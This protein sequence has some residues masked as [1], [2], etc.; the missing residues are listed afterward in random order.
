MDEKPDIQHIRNLDPHT[1]TMKRYDPRGRG[2]DICLRAHSLTQLFQAIAAAEKE[3]DTAGFTG[4]QEYEAAQAAA[5]TATQT[6]PVAPA[7]RP[8]SVTAEG[9]QRPFRASKM[10]AQWSD[11]RN[12]WNWRVF[13]N[14]MPR[15][16]SQH[17]IPIWD[18]GLEASGF[19][20]TLEGPTPKAPQVTGMLVEWEIREGKEGKRFPRVLAMAHPH[21]TGE[22]ETSGAAPGPESDD[23]IPF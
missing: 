3:C 6:D 12:Q 7:A 5:H 8:G 10:T 19:S 15:Q 14:D 13:G 16:F 23:D 18:E 2:Y 21:A 4:W 1:V 22:T 17:G 11:T 9:P 20:P